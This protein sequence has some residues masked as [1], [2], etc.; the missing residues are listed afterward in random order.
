MKKKSFK[1]GNLG[2]GSG[3]GL[4]GAV[5]ESGEDGLFALG[6][7]GICGNHSVEMNYKYVQYV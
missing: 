2:R 1:M 4:P 7:V 5:F 6:S 3:L